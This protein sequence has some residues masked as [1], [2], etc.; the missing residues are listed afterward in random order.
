MAADKIDKSDAHDAG[1]MLHRVLYSSSAISAHVCH[2]PVP[3]SENAYCHVPDF[4]RWRR[5]PVTCP[6]NFVDDMERFIFLGNLKV[7]SHFFRRPIRLAFPAKL[8]IHSKRCT[9]FHGLFERSF[10]PCSADGL[11]PSM[12]SCKQIRPRGSSAK[13]GR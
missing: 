2:L 5:V 9:S 1:R 10:I 3:F 4:H 6:S 7:L 11:C 13:Q 12:G 8:F